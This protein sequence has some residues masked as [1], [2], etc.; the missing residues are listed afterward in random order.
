MLGKQLSNCISG[1]II[2]R[3]IKSRHASVDIVF[4]RIFSS[5]LAESSDSGKGTGELSGMMHEFYAMIWT[6]D[7]DTDRYR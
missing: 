3:K 5:E 7:I 6:K 2:I 1:A 4:L